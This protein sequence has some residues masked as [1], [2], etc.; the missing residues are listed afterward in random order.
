[1]IVS[2]G[3]KKSNSWLNLAGTSTKIAGIFIETHPNL[4]MHFVM[5]RLLYLYQNSDLL[6]QI[7]A[8]DKLVK[9]FSKNEVN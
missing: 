9:S 4:M 5:V 6:K 2:L 3:E 7:I 8:L 1:M